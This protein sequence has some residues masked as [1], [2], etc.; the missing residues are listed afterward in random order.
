MAIFEPNSL[1]QLCNVPINITGK[2]QLD[3]SDA[4]SQL[5][6]FSSHVV[7]SFNDFTFQ[8]KD[9]SIKIPI[10]IDKFYS[11]NANYVIYRNRYYSDKYFYCF[12]IIRHMFYTIKS[13]FNCFKSST[14]LIKIFF[15][16]PTL[17]DV[18]FKRVKVLT[19]ISRFLPI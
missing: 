12:I 3:F 10:E 7:I 6:Y 13:M 9:K 11:L 8:R 17:Y 19:P 2:N 18:D 16:I 5:A 1:I 4:S 14:Y 15:F